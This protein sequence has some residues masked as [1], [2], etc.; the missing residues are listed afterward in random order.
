[1]LQEGVKR[2][3]VSHLQCCLPSCS[4]EHTSAVRLEAATQAYGI[5]LPSHGFLSRCTP[6][7]TMP[8]EHVRCCRE[9][10]LARA[11][12][13]DEGGGGGGD[14]GGGGGGGSYEPMGGGG[15]SSMSMGSDTSAPAT[16]SDATPTTNDD[17]PSGNDAS[18]SEASPS[19]S[20]VSPSSSEVSPSYS[21]A[22]P[23]YTYSDVY[24]TTSSTVSTPRNTALRCS[25]SD[26]S[27]GCG[28]GL[29]VYCCETAIGT[30]GGGCGSLSDSGLSQCPAN[31]PH[32]QCC[33]VS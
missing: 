10:R 19:G 9:S 16:T 20:E 3:C 25:R 6:W 12:L 8:D 14:G 28:S 24:L 11:L 30:P 4:P 2:R 1:M 32:P 13:Q 21:D 31:Y 22:S 18:P 7:R 15:G 29:D 27:S 33:G 5:Q 23:S 26:P 17:S